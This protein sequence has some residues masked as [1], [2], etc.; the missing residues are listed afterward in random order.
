MGVVSGIVVFVILWWTV[1][2]TV[3]PWGNRAP[4]EPELGHAPSAP[5]NPHL[6]RK[7]AATTAITVVLWLVVFAVVEAELIS[8]RDIAQGIRAG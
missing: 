7:F 3:L 6:W 8:F 2:F 1:L 4:A 5:R